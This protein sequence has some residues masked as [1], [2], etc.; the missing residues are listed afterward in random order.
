[1]SSNTT[2]ELWHIWAIANNELN[3]AGKLLNLDNKDD[4]DLDHQDDPSD[5]IDIKKKFNIMINAWNVATD[6]TEKDNTESIRVIIL[7]MAPLLNELFSK[8]ELFYIK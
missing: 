6:A 1:M 7:L 3:E 8:I 2:L 4:V 5:F